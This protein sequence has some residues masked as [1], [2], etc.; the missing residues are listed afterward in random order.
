MLG[1]KN[2]NRFSSQLKFQPLFFPLGIMKEQNKNLGECKYLSFKI[3]ITELQLS[4]QLNEDNNK[5]QL[6]KA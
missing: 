6:F 3:I 2:K 5:L 4:H 1:T